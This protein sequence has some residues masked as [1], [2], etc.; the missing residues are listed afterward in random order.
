M[1]F[2]KNIIQLVFLRVLETDRRVVLPTNTHSRLLIAAVD[3]LHSQTIP[4]F[5]GK[6]LASDRERSPGLGFT[7]PGRLFNQHVLETI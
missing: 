1:S 2:Y 7:P 4:S 3:V 6:H 5:G